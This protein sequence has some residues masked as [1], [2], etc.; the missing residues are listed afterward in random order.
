MIFNHI[1]F[2][3]NY[4]KGTKVVPLGFY[5]YKWYRVYFPNE[6]NMRIMYMDFSTFLYQHTAPENIDTIIFPQHDLCILP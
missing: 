5:Y 3:L 4:K 6:T 2:E 1:T